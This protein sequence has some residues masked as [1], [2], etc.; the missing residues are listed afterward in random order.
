MLTFDSFALEYLFDTVKVYQCT[1]AQCTNPQLVASLSGTLT[2]VQ[3]YTI[4]TGY[5]LV[6]FTTDFSGEYAGFNAT[7]AL[8]TVGIMLIY[9]CCM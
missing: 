8:Y 4:T 5:V 7:W 9:A 1:V 6:L 3:S 2:G